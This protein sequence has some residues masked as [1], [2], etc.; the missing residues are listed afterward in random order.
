[1]PKLRVGHIDLPESEDN[2]GQHQNICASAAF[3]L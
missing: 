3:G 2:H 1:M